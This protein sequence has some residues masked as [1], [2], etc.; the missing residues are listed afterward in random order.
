M[1]LLIPLGH[2]GVIEI[3][4]LLTKHLGDFFQ[5]TSLLSTQKQHTGTVT[6]N[7]FYMIFIDRF[8]LRLGLHHNVCGYLSASDNADDMLKIRYLLV[9]KFIQQTGHMVRQCT[10]ASKCFLARTLNI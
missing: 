10:A 7:R 1:T 6:N 2:T 4:R 8:E 5:G 3:N 9:C